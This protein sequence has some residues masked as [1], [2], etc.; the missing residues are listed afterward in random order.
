MSTDLHS[1][2]TCQHPLVQPLEERPELVQ[3]QLLVLEQEL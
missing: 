2:H 1:A 3:P